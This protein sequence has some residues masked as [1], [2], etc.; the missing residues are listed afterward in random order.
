MSSAKSLFNKAIIKMD[1]K[2]YWWMSAI[3]TGMIFMISVFPFLNSCW[4]ESKGDSSSFTG[5]YFIGYGNYSIIAIAIMAVLIAVFL[6]SYLQKS[7]SVTSFHAMPIKREGFY[8][9]HI[10]SGLILMIIPIIVNAIIL[11]LSR[12]NYNVWLLCRTSYIVK[13]ALLCIL[14]TIGA[15]SVGTLCSMVTGNTAA[16]FVLTY[17]IIGLPAFIEGVIYIFASS[18]L[19]G[20]YSNGANLFINKLYYDFRGVTAHHARGVI[21]YIVITA[22]AFILGLVFYKKRD[23]ENHSMVVSFKVLRP[24]FIYAFGIC[25]GILGFMYVNEFNGNESMLLMLPFG[26]VGIIAAKMLISL[27]LKPKGMIK[28]LLIYTVFVLAVT[29]A[30][31]F[32]IFGFIRRVPDVK[33]IECIIVNDYDG[34]DGSRMV[35]GV[36]ARR[37]YVYDRSIRDEAAIKK[38][39]DIHRELTKKDG[40]MSEGR[41]MNLELQYKLKDNSV[42]RRAYYIDEETGRK[43]FEIDDYKKN[44][45]HILYD[46]NK[47][48]SGITI[49]SPVFGRIYT[50][51]SDMYAAFY[52]AMKKDAWL[53]TYD[54]YTCHN[55]TLFIAADYSYPAVDMNGKKLSSPIADSDYIGIYK[56]SVN[57]WELL[58]SIDIF[59]R[60]DGKVASVKIGDKLINDAEK[61]KFIYKRLID[62]TIDYTEPTV[63]YDSVD[64]NKVVYTDEQNTS[65][66]VYKDGVL[67]VFISLNDERGMSLTISCTEAEYNMLIS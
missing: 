19:R 28:P 59:G 25:I 51:D 20:Y 36:M 52:D 63:L 43:L 54:E 57:T 29:G 37:E 38:I 15:F 17:I 45:F 9:S 26:I 41:H 1:L 27:S 39:T 7:A 44:L 31:K 61:K 22:A 30:F 46:D 23:L 48:I 32:D 55:D 2:R 34:Y 21:T 16:A 10:L 40:S 65:D 33:D 49:S 64:T 62:R 67:N 50:V 60:I 6:F 5:S 14:Y 53:R 42:M 58:N 35:D 4:I 56:S 3:Y 66:E 47:S 18:F 8:A 12:F 24:I 11:L 13:W